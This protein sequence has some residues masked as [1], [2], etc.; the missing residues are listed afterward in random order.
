MNACKYSSHCPGCREK[1]SEMRTFIG[2]LV[3][4]AG[5]AMATA[6]VTPQPGD[7]VFTSQTGSGN[8]SIKLISGTVPTV[9]AA[10]NLYSSGNSAT[11]FAGIQQ[12]PDGNFYVAD[13]RF[14]FP[15]TTDAGIIKIS[16]LFSGS[17]VAS[18]HRQGNPFQNPLG[19]VWSPATNEFVT[20]SNPGTPQIPATLDAVIGFGTSGAGS[21]VYY[22][23]PNPIGSGRPTYFGAHSIIRD[24]RPGSNDLLI[25]NVNGG[26]ATNPTPFFGF[27]QESSTVWRMTFTGSGYTLNPAPV[28]DFASSFT[29]FASSFFN[30]RGMAA[31]PG[32]NSFF[33]A[34]HEAGVINKVTMDISGNFT[35][36]QTILSGL[37]FPENMVYN[38]YTNQLVFGERS[39][40]GG[41]TSAKIS[42]VNLDGTGLTTL[43]TGE[44]ARGFT[45]VPTPGAAAL[46]GVSGLV[47]TRR[48]RR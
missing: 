38:Q 13:G 37:D 27:D 44:H 36:I 11:R 29:G 2:F 32:T 1:E 17:P 22:S 26:T 46:L 43:Y 14:P 39:V 48:R 15:N 20:V 28:V 23:E 33:I 7:I 24:P 16:G 31:V 8:D 47:A 45:I 12:G 30:S 42:T 41:F 18:S 6:Q 34:D 4:S 9:G 19:L 5:A 35:G 25:S 3:V 40:V 21:N 10:T